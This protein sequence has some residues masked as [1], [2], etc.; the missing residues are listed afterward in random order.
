[1]EELQ[2]MKHKN[3][4]ILVIRK[5]NMHMHVNVRMKTKTNGEMKIAR[6]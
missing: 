2:E 5:E 6:R 3:N 1:M 4:K